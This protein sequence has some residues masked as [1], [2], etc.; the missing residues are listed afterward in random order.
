MKKSAACVLLVVAVSP[1]RLEAQT[2]EMTQSV[3][4]VH[5]GAAN[6]S[7]LKKK[8]DRDLPSIP[9]SMVLGKDVKF[10]RYEVRTYRAGEDGDPPQAFE[11]LKSGRRIYST[12]ND[13]GVKYEI[14][15]I[16]DDEAGNLEIRPEKTSRA[17]ENPT[18][19]Y[20]IGQAERT[21]ASRT[22]SLNLM[23]TRGRLVRSTLWMAMVANFKRSTT[24]KLIS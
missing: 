9:L 11:I 20:Q 19:S 14:G 5:Q 6:G 13:D 22:M 10:E 16:N 15:C 24:A 7:T 1:Y 21:A 17:Q 12:V 18:W 2:H 8:E 23:I 4:A 3:E